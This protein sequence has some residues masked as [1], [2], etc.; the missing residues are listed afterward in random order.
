MEQDLANFFGIDY[1]DRWRPGGGAS[2]LT[3]RRLLV[4][5]EGM[6]RGNSKFWCA[7][8]DRDPL[9]LQ[10]SLIMNVWESQTG[11]PHPYRSRR[12]N[13]RKQAE[14]ER[15]KQQIRKAER[16]R[17]KLNRLSKALG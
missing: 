16:L 9:T 3:L 15:K 11:E 5:I 14:F 13:E 8:H 10:E 1:R 17:K 2:Q 6:D 4:L 12:E 7:V